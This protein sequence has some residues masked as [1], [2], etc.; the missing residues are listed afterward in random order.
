MP[1]TIE[2][3]RSPLTD[4][5]ALSS[6]VA[7]H[8]LLVLFASLI[9]LQAVLPG[10][11]EEES[12]GLV[13]E[14]GPVDNRAGTVNPGGGPGDLGGTMTPEQ[15]ALA[16]ATPGA[17]PTATTSEAMA[18]ALVDQILAVPAAADPNAEALPLPAAPGIGVLPGPG[19]GGGGG[20]GGGSGGGKGLGLGAG[21]E[22]FGAKERATSFAYVI[23][24]SASMTNRG[25]IDIAKRELLSSLKPTAARHQLRRHLLQREADELHRRPAAS[26]A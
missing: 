6:S 20:E 22:F 9:V 5:R 7:F 24:R 12:P 1:R 26:G 14:L 3:G 21:T 16:A 25:S 2:I 11:E 19:T 13:G 23:D 17:A 8:A 4:P 15:M 10:G 18:D